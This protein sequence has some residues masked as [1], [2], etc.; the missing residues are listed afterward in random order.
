MYM[1]FINTTVLNTTLSSG[2]LVVSPFFFFINMLNIILSSGLPVV[3]PL[4]FDYL[5]DK[6]TLS[7][8]TQFMFGTGIM[9]APVL[10]PVRYHAAHLI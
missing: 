10:K 7:I 5:D 9:F 8:E 4:F 3:S 6:N 1:C 2:L